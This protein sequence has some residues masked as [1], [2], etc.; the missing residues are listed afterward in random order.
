MFLIVGLGNIGTKYQHTRHNI[1]FDAVDLISS[2]Y[3]IP[4]NREKFKG[5]Y[6][7]G[8][9][10]DNKVMLLKPSTYMNLSGESVIEAANFFKIKS[11]NIIII[12]DDI[13]LEI[14]R[15]R[16]R[17]HGSAG[18]HNGIKSVIANLG[19][20]VFPRIKVGI[21][22]PKGDLVSH[23]LGKFDINERNDIEKVL[24][25][26][27]DVLECLINCGVEEAMNKFNGLKISSDS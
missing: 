4:I 26:S 24:E 22:Q 17:K 8:I 13:D 14:G 6:G 3:N 18:G 7:E 16:I 1:G 20:D 12:Y 15:I 5:T 11:S 27:A 9:I 25:T 2:K 10:A 21:G 23:V 19:T